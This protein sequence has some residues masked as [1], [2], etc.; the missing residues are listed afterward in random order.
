MTL[1]PDYSEEA[2]ADS[3]LEQV[4]QMLA[5]MLGPTVFV[6]ITYRDDT[7]ETKVM[8]LTEADLLR[9]NIADGAFPDIARLKVSSPLAGTLAA[10]EPIRAD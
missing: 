1:I 4:R 5:D 3:L 9:Q 2:H 7:T 6:D 10:M 8:Y